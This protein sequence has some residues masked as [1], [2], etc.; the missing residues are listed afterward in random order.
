MK[1]ITATAVLF[2]V[3]L[4]FVLF[5]PK[6]DIKASADFTY[7]VTEDFGANGSD[8]EDDTA[9]F[10]TALDKAKMYAGT[11]EKITIKVPKGTYY[12]ENRLLI[13]SNTTLKLDK[14]A[15]LKRRNNLDYIIVSGEDAPEYQSGRLLSHDIIIDGGIWDGNPSCTDQSKGVIKIYNSDKVSLLNADVRNIVGTHFVLFDGVSNLNVKNCS[16]SN[17]IHYTGTQDTYRNQVFAN[18]N[19]WAAEA[20]HIDFLDKN[21]SLLNGR[22]Y[23][24]CKNVVVSGCK[25]KNLTSALGTHHVFD[26]MSQ[27]NIT[28]K[29]NVFE[30]CSYDCINAAS[31]SNM[32]VYNNKAIKCGGFLAARRTSGEVYN[33]YAGLIKNPSGVMYTCGKFGGKAPFFYGVEIS[34][35]SNLTFRNNQIYS[36]SSHG[37]MVNT[38][39][40]VNIYDNMIS[41]SKGNGIA[42]WGGSSGKIYRNNITMSLTNGISVRNGAKLTDC[43]RNTISGS[44]NN[45]VYSNAA[46]I[47]SA[48]YNSISSSKYN[49]F[50]LASGSKAVIADND[51]SGSKNNGIYVSDRSNVKAASN[52]IHSCKSSGVVF[53]GNS[54]GTVTK[55]SFNSNSKYDLHVKDKCKN[56]IFMTNGSDKSK[57]KVEGGCKA[58]IS[59][60]KKSLK[61]SYFKIS[62]NYTYTGKQIKPAVSSALK[63]NTDYT[64]SY[65]GNKSTGEGTVTVT[66]KGKY[67]GS[68]TLRFNILPKQA[69]LTTAVPDVCH[70]VGLCWNK[71]SQASGYDIIYSVNSN[72]KSGKHVYVTKNGTT[73]ARITGLT[74]GK[75]YYVKIRSYKVINGS[76]CY[77]A[78][79]KSKNFKA[80]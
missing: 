22:P 2:A 46:L 15:H 76:K 4:V 50:S 56:I 54:S 36:A 78:W 21:S 60:S 16:F 45:G 77:G 12:I 32:K 26:Y 62:S 31:F 14:N 10:Q 34:N 75:K 40:S 49:G 5:A 57:T 37:I 43:S 41:N 61:S 19:Y 17:F 39:S 20:L 55:N 42:L 30:N 72:F 9:A 58:S 18:L 66:G 70:G 23:V 25:F 13:Y 47:S 8:T 7:S 59:K 48:K 33:N 79:S 71:D 74:K 28:I 35:K 52:Y 38:N 68:F 44:G 63:K 24:P 64:V 80:K 29:D 6:S 53:T 67:S 27:D 51:I 1:K 73:S 65:G 69:K 3:A 11:N